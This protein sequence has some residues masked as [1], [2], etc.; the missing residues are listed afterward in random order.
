LLAII[1][2]FHIQLRQTD[3]GGG[4]HYEDQ[5]ITYD[6]RLDDDRTLRQA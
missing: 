2:R 3:N 4:G 1:D 5:D 6:A